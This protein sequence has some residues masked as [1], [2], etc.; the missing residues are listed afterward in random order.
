MAKEMYEVNFFG[1]LRLIQ[2]V[3]PSMKARQGGHIINNSSHLGIVG[4]PFNALYCSTKFALEG[5]T[6]AIAPTLL[7]FNIKCS[8]VEE[9]P[10]ATAALINSRN[11]ASSHDMPPTD[12]KTQE[13]FG[14]FA[15]KMQQQ[16]K[17]TAQNSDEIAEIVKNIIL[18]EKPSL[19]YQTNE[20]YNPHEV[21]GK[22]LDPTGNNTVEMMQAFFAEEQ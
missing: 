6:E 3:M 14:R 13:L 11:W 1:A 18:C 20:K 21:K 8:L 12:Q 16:F 5:L 4:T 10:V 17:S 9:G 19:R 7:H 22:L 15:A 2:S